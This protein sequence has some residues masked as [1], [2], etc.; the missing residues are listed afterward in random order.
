MKYALKHKLKILSGRSKK[1]VVIGFNKTGTTSITSA[2]KELGFLTASQSQ[3]ERLL[4]DIIRGDYSKVIDFMKSGE[5]FQDIPFSLPN[6]YKHIYNKYPNAKFIL[7]IRDNSDQ[8]YRSLLNFHSKI[9]GNGDIPSEQNLSKEIYHYKGFPLDYLK[10]TFGEELYDEAQY[11]AVYEKHINDVIDFF[12][13]KHENLIIINT[14]KD[15]DYFKLC[16]YLKVNPK[17]NNFE[18]KN[19][20][21]EIE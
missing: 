7:T 18:W 9:W 4:P 1:I 21:T 15:S 10:F 13:D 3:S 2:L 8:W 11:K 17:R 5:V 16:D 12:L 6:I 14:S 19:K 20:T